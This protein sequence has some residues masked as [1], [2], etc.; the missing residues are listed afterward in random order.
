MLTAYMLPFSDENGFIASEHKSAS[1]LSG[2]GR[3]DYCVGKTSRSHHI[4]SNL[5]RLH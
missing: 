4:F 3:S 5:N 2:G 1:S